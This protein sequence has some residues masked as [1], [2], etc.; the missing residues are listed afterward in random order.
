[1]PDL[2]R[3]DVHPIKALD[4]QSVER[5]TVLPGGALAWDRRYAIVDDDG[6][7]VNGKREAALHRIA[8]EFDLDAGTVAV[9]E[10]GGG[11]RERFHLDDDR[12]AL[13]GWLSA[14]LGYEVDL[15][16]DDDG[17]PDRTDLG[18]PTVVATGTLERVGEWF[19][20]DPANVRR[21][22]RANLVVDAPAFWEDRLYAGQNE[23]RRFTVG[24]VTF[25]GVKPCGRCVVPTRD[26]DTGEAAPEDFQARFVERRRETLPAFADESWYDHHFRLCPVTRLAADESEGG[27]GSDRDGAGELAVGDAVELGDV[28]P[29]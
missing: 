3:I 18:G 9:G 4:P 5:A 14:F 7:Y 26:P 29:R 1:M 11:D 25:D 19:D 24:D 28:R 13:A 21:R 23:V 15:V 12:A 16:R 10:R 2:A 6:A 17:L 20:L 27:D 22:F 8:T